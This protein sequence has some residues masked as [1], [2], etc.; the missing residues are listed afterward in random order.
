M[1]TLFYRLPRLTLLIIFIAIISGIGAILTLGR[2]EDPTL[3]E[4]FGYVLTAM[5]G[6]DA[7]RVEAIVT[8]PIE[9]RLQQ[10]PEIAEIKSTSRANVSQISIDVREDLTEAEVDDAWT[11]IR[12]QVELARAELPSDVR[13]PIVER[14]YVGAATMLVSLSWQGEGDPPLAV[15]ARLAEGLE[16][17]LRNLSATEETELF[18]QPREEVRVVADPEALAAAGLSMTE[19]ARLIG[20][21]DAKAPA[22]QFRGSGSDIG[23]EIGG[24]FDGIARIRAVPL[25]Q[26]PDGSALRVGDIAEVEKGIENPPTG[27]AFSDGKRAIFVAAYIQS[28]NRV[29]Q[30]ALQAEAAV[31]DFAVN[32]PG[33]IKVDITFSQAKYTN[34]RLNGLAQNLLISALIVFAVLFFV[35]GW[36][37]AIVVG[38]ALPLTVAL[39]L[40]LFRLFNYPLHQMSVTGLVISL[41]LLIDNAIVVVDEY[42]QERAGGRTVLDAIDHSLGKLFGPLFAST[43]TTALAFAPI[44]LMPGAAGEFIG[45][46]GTS[47]IFSVVCSFVIA[48]TV[49]PAV[50]GWLDRP[51]QAVEVKRWWRDGIKIDTVTDGYRWTIGTV[52]RYPILGVLIGVVP[53][54]AGFMLGGSLPSQFFPQTERDQFQVEITLPPQATIYEGIDAAERAE[55]LLKQRYPQITGIHFAVGEPGPRV[56]YNAFNNQRGVAGYAAG[57]V[58]LR[59]NNDT[60]VLVADVQKFLR[61]EFPEAQVLAIPFEQGPPAD[62]PIAFFIEGNSLET[63][64][65]LGNEA[66]SILAETPGITFT[67][68]RLQLGAPTLTIN[69]DEAATAISG[70]RL[71]GLAADLRAEL[72]GVPA[73]S[74]LEGIEEVPVRVIAPAQRRGELVDLRSKTIGNGAQGAGTPLA[75]LGEVKLDPQTAV[76]VRLNGQRVNEIYGYTE[77]YSLPDPIFAE[78]QSKLEVRGFDLPPGYSLRIGGQAENQADAMADLLTLAVPLILVMVGAVALVFNSF[79]MSFLIMA[80]G[81]MSVGLAFGG[82]WMFNLPMGFNAIVGA[83]GLL[84]IAINGSIVVLSLLQGNEAARNDDVIAQREVVVAATRHIVATT[85]TTMG[86]FVPII[87]TGDVFWLPLATAIAGGVAGSALLALYFAPAMYRIM[88]MKPIYRLFRLLSGKGWTHPARATVAAE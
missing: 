45:M 84:G 28:N 30:W 72:E 20:A 5:P 51:R 3:V 41:G 14:V 67:Q 64:N 88:T 40:L 17:R 22:G 33:D 56:Y 32:I 71:T 49:I 61:T 54:M 38:L 27:L 6:A 25:L 29:D 76:I 65:R 34:E 44:A 59:S 18:G 68:A 78:F 53:V 37:S 12:S 10:L 83:L 16:D 55:R 70:L 77:P 1:T 36:R 15:M 85:L 2:Q 43:L 60:R 8:E 52:L 39:V 82:V 13:T 50:A 23:V 74:I 42:D 46:I 63:L 57:F 81:G 48:M 9:R 7:E 31:E 62:A 79:R 69:A 35:M 75:A 86:G 24:E 58:Q 11:L 4:R 80:I 66:R 87:L 21:G 19:A 73:G 47:V 26:R